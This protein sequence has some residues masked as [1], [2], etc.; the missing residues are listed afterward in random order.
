MR[1]QFTAPLFLLVIVFLFSSIRLSYCKKQTIHVDRAQDEKYTTLV[2]LDGGG[3]RGII[4]AVVLIELEDSIKRHILTTRPELLPEDAQ[5]QSIDDFEISLADYIDCI[6]GNSIGALIALYLTSKGGNGK[7]SELLS[8]KDIVERYGEIAPTSAKGLI[9]TFYEFAD[10]VFP[11]DLITGSVFNAG[12]NPADPGVIRPWLPNAIGLRNLTE[13]MVGETRMSELHTSCFIIAYDIARRS[14]ILVV[15]DELESSPKYGFSQQ[16]RSNTP[17]RKDNAFNREVQA[18]YGVDFYV[19][20]IAVGSASLPVAFPAHEAISTTLPKQSLLLV[21][22]LFV[23]S[24][25]VLHSLLQIANSTGDTSFS[26]VAV[27]SIGAGLGLPDLTRAANGGAAQWDGTGNR[28]YYSLNMFGGVLHKEIE[29]LF[30]ANPEVK[31]GQFLRIEI[32]EEEGTQR[33]GLLRTSTVGA[34]LPQLE[35][36]GNEI[37]QKFNSSIGAFVNNFIFT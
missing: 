11:P 29:F 8:R 32:F 24:T 23:L 6:A 34:V 19:S 5:V 28:L 12:T 17:R 31:P 16:V 27:M 4:S 21:D 35:A 37:A 1:Q 2:S 10:V 3:L 26:R 13:T 33:Y 20:D 22:G 9:V 36:I 14:E 15:Y 7:A 30:S 25:P 18:V